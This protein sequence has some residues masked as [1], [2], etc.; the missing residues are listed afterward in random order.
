MALFGDAIV[1]GIALGPF[2]GATIESNL[3]WRWYAGTL[4]NASYQANL[5]RI[6]HVQLIFDSCCVPFFILIL[7]E[8]KTDFILAHRA[9]RARGPDNRSF[10]TKWTERSKALM[11]AVIE[12]P[13]KPTHMTF[14]EPI[15]F[16][17]FIW[18]GYAWGILFLLTQSV[19][20]TFGKTY[21]FSLLASNTAYL[22]VGAGAILASFLQP[23][24]DSLFMASASR[25]KENPG[26][27]IPEARLYTAIPGQVLFA[28][29]LFWYGWASQS[30]VH[31]FVPVGGVA[32]IGFGIYTTYMAVYHY[33]TDVF[34]RHSAGA[35]GATSFSRFIFCGFLGLAWSTM[36]RNMGIQWAA[37]CLGFIG[38]AL[39]LAPVIMLVK[40]EG[41]RRRSAYT[42]KTVK[43]E[44]QS[45][46]SMA[47]CDTMDIQRVDV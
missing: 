11:R 32:C 5:N 37:S 4:N 6:Y 36:N 47:S 15:V 39:T 3:T 19:V 26:Q 17:C 27:P 8:T 14:T 42:L 46:V 23:I 40:G 16:L 1:V 34:P 12:S 43:E 35:N 44:V 30:H 24:Q 29:G 45:N 31:W 13:K 20:Q 33:C 10:S 41:M 21:G 22:A 38:L 25:N 9:K 18:V 7:R 2:I 28:G